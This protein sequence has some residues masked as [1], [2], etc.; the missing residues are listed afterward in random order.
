M[1]IIDELPKDKVEEIIDFAYFIRQR[2]KTENDEQKQ[3]EKEAISL[4]EVMGLAGIVG[5][6]GDALEDSE[7]LY[8]G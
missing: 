2:A 5:W 1:Q 7:R 4:D 3:T 6:G 8:E